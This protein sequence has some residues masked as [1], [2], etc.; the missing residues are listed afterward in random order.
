MITTQGRRQKAFTL[1]RTQKW[2]RRSNKSLQK[3]RPEQWLKR[4]L[5]D[6]GFA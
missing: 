6:E 3:Q 4:Y 1:R 2:C 5:L